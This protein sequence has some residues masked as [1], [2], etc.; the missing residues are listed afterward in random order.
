M[1]IVITASEFTPSKGYLEFY[2]AKELT[3]L[4]HKVFIFTFGCSSRVTKT[5]SNEGFEVI[6]LPHFVSVNG[7]Q[8]PKLSGIAYVLR[9]IKKQKLDVI[10]CQ[11]LFSPLS[12]LFM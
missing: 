11:P 12:L 8:A 3:K 5:T 2:L 7:V 9:F 1:K 4:G 6:S 10:H